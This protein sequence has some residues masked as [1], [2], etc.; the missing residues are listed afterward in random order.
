MRGKGIVQGLTDGEMRVERKKWTLFWEMGG[1][2][3]ERKV[4]FN[5]TGQ[6]GHCR[7]KEA[8]TKKRKK[9]DEGKGG[10]DECH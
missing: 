1:W 6:R 8:D 5:K 10:E 9:T 7:I 4:G 3:N 2:I